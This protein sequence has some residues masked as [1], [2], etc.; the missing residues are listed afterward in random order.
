MDVKIPGSGT[1]N[2]IEGTVDST[3]VEVTGSGAFNRM[4]A[5]DVNV[6]A[7]SA[8]VA[9][10][11]VVLRNSD[12]VAVG[13]GTTDSNGDAI[14]MTFTTDMVD[15]SGLTTMNLAGYEVVTVAKVG[16]YYYNSQSDNAGDFRYAMDQ[17]S[18]ADTSG[19]YTRGPSRHC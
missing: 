9:G 4:R 11:N 19:N 13:S 3:S 10:T 2:F 5:L 12:G 16:A 7:D 8:A 6:E 15:S 14:G 1:V 18:L 17:V